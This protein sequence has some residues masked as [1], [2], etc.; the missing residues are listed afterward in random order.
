M[1]IPKLT[2]IQLQY[3]FLKNRRIWNIIHNE[4][5]FKDFKKL[6]SWVIFQTDVL[7][8]IVFSC[9]ATFQ[10]SSGVPSLFG[11]GNDPT[12]EIIFKVWLSVKQGHVQK[13]L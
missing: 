13:F 11:Y 9:N 6:I 7:I 1:L 10:P 12:R 3:I 4:F 2:Q 8:F 5:F